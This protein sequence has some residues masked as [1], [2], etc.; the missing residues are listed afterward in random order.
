MNFQIGYANVIRVSET[1]YRNYTVA[2]HDIE[3]GIFDII[4][5]LHGKGVGCQYI[6]SLVTNDELYISDDSF[7]GDLLL[8]IAF[9]KAALMLIAAHWIV[10]K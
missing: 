7:F 10:F 9:R 8:P 6:D 3:K 4:F 5:H 2:Y 1:E